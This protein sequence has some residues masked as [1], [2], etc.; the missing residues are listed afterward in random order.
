MSGQRQLTLYE[1]AVIGRFMTSPNAL[2][3]LVCL[4]QGI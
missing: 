3:A 2:A 1:K 4:G